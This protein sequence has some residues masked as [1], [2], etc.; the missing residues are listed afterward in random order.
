[1]FIKEDANPTRLTG[2]SSKSNERMKVKTC[3]CLTNRRNSDNRE[4]LTDAGAQEGFSCN[5]WRRME[6]DASPPSVP[7][8]CK[9]RSLGLH[10]AK[11]SPMSCQTT[12]YS[13]CGFHKDV[14]DSSGVKINMGN[15][16]ISINGGLVR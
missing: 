1:M 3:V 15:N 6:E 14:I 7:K 13:K 11:C 8:A 4:F 12:F 10:P 16:S 2:L 5:R 9:T